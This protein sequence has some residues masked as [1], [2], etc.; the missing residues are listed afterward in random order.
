MKPDANIEPSLL[1]V[2]RGKKYLK[3]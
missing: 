2:F 3:A 1:R